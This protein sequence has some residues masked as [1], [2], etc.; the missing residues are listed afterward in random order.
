MNTTY[1][2]YIYLANLLVLF[3]YENPWDIVLNALAVE[4]IKD[5]DESF[6][7]TIAYDTDYRYLKA[8]AIEMVIN[9]FLDNVSALRV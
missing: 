3:T 6:T 5:I 7:S 9:R 4:F 1:N 8:G 2:S